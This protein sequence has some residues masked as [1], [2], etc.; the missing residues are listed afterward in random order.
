MPA[1][2]DAHET[3]YQPVATLLADARRHQRLANDVVRWLSAVTVFSDIERRNGLSDDPCEQRAFLKIVSDLISAGRA[4]LAQMG[5]DAPE[6]LNQADTTPASFNACLEFLEM[7]HDAVA[8]PIAP[9]DL[10]KL[11]AYFSHDPGT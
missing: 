11:N 5:A 2:L 10:A 8:N 9:A 7:T 6:I 1:L 4:L 3:D